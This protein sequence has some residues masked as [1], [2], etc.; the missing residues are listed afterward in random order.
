MPLK[1]MPG[2][3]DCV[4][5]HCSYPVRY[6]NAAPIPAKAPPINNDTITF[7]FSRIPLYFAA[8]LA[9]PVARISYPKTVM[10]SR[11]LSSM[12]MITDSGIA[13]VT[14]LLL[15]NSLSSPSV[16][17][18]AAGLALA[19]LTVYGLAVS[20]TTLRSIFTVY[21]PIQLSMI[22]DITSF[23]FKYAFRNPT[24]IPKIPPARIAANRH[25]L[26]CR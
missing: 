5:D 13:I 9:I 20:F 1:P 24:A 26:Q 2:T 16:G 8:S 3:E 12:A 14:Y 7:L 15:E 25:K 6:R 19:R 22:P 18:T 21:K 10:D 11:I 4:T 17:S 23:T